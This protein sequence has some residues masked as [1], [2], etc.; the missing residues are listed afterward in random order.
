MRTITPVPPVLLN[1]AP[2]LVC[3]VLAPLALLPACVDSN[4]R[5][6][7]GET[8]VLPAMEPSPPVPAQYSQDAPSTA[9]LDRGTWQP[10][11]FL[12]PVDGTHHRPTYADPLFLTDATR[13]QR[14]EFPTIE[15]ALD[16]DGSEFGP[17][18]SQERFSEGVLVPARAFLDAVAMP[19]RLV[20]EPQTWELVSPKFD[21]Q[22]RPDRALFMP[23]ARPSAERP[24][25]TTQTPAPAEDEPF[26]HSQ[27]STDPR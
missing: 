6:T 1:R 8:V 9:H 2:R 19:V 13:R 10:T 23:P 27:P 11:I 5:T 22:R 17:E 25:T 12:V 3:G 18:A 15:S 14:G 21:Y 7:I 26:R 4:S 24:E 20:G 16:L